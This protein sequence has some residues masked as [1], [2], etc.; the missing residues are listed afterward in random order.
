M[1]K[2]K[3]LYYDPKEGLGGTSKFYKKA[4]ALGY[5]YNQ[6]RAFLQ[7]QEA[8]QVHRQT[9][10]HYFPIRTPPGCYQADLMF[11]DEYRGYKMIICIINSSTRYAYCYAMKKKE[12]VVEK[13]KKFFSSARDEVFEIQTDKGSE[14]VNK[15]V[16]ALLEKE[17]VIL[18]TVDTGDHTAQ[19]KVERFNQTLRN[20]IEKYKV[21]YKSNDWPG[22]LADLVHNYN[23][24]EHTGL[25]GKAPAD[26]DE[27]DEVAR[28]VLRMEKAKK[29]FE[30]FK[31]GDR[32]RKI[33]KKL[34]FDKGR[35]KWSHEVYTIAAIKHH[36]FKLEDD[37]GNDAGLMK[38]YEVQL[39]NKV[40]RKVENKM[41]KPEVDKRE[42]R[43]KQQFVREQ[44]N[45]ENITDAKRQRKKKERLIEIDMHG[46]GMGQ[47]KGGK[48]KK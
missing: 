34:Q 27:L 10:T 42:K 28:Q 14:F 39:V 19:G 18:R 15:K 46:E 47:A 44:V 17:G 48:K 4:K 30:Q 20:L 23:H 21:A 1:D 36:R 33:V 26:A 24:R 31:V 29:Q 11:L 35:K 37:E 7:E 13:L 9:K 25:G 6:V 12:E 16:K 38:H 5:T 41:P 32:V 3:E 22:A 43:V 2:L 40:E 45:E 8:H